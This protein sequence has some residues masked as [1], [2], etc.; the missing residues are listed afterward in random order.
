M[1][2][3]TET[4]GF[5]GDDGGN[6]EGRGDECF[7]PLSLQGREDARGQIIHRRAS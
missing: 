3:R 1:T 4:P 6:R 7:H 2:R 5:R